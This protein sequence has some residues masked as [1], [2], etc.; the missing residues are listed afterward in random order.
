VLEARVDG[1]TTVVRRLRG[2]AADR[3]VGPTTARLA[4]A[5][6]A[7][8]GFRPNSASSLLDGVQAEKGEKQ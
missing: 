7:F 1:D 4:S 2:C 8:A 5:A 3:R 6:A